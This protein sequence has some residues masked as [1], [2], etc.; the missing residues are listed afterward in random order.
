MKILQI[1]LRQQFLLTV[2]LGGLLLLGLI[3]LLIDSTH[4]PVGR[5]RFVGS[6]P[7]SIKP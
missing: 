2:F 7:L 1:M 4:Q 6:S 5:S 3:L